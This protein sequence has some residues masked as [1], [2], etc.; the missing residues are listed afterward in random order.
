MNYLSQILTVITLAFHFSFSAQN[1]TQDIRIA[2]NYFIAG[3][4]DK[5][6]MYFDKISQDESITNEIYNYYRLCLLELDRFKDAER[7]CKTVIKTNPENLSYN[8]DLG[9]VYDKWEKTQKRDQQFSK[10]VDL[11]QPKTNYS[12]IS[13]LAFAFEKIGELNY[14]IQVYTAGNKYNQTNPYAYHQKLAYI[15][16]KQ[17]ET[18]KMIDI[19]LELIKQSEGFLSVVQSGFSNSIDFNSDFKAKELLLLEKWLGK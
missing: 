15:Y 2:N 4:Y 16:N 9:L 11:I 6:V 3:D 12:Q 10:S 1:T 5:A 8:V 7:L 18:Q 19:F 14:A 17:G 13:A